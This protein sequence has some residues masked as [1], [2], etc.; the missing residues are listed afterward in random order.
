MFMAQHETPQPGFSPDEAAKAL[1][2]ET[3]PTRDLAHGSGVGFSVNGPEGSQSLEV[4]DNGKAAR[5]SGPR[6]RLEAVGTFTPHVAEGRVWLT[7]T[8]DQQATTLGLRADGSVIFQQAVQATERPQK[9]ETPHSG[10]NPCLENPAAPTD[11][12][13]AIPP[14]DEAVQPDE[15]P[16]DSTAGEQAPSKERGTVVSIV[17][18]L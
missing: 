12:T 10:T 7:D 17:G 5:L 8:T 1:S 18:R 3:Y 2:G 11:P 16:A 14:Q 6:F 9:N 13:L 4:F 15:Q